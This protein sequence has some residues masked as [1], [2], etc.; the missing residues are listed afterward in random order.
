MCWLLFLV[1]LHPELFFFFLLCWVFQS[2]C[3]GLAAPTAWGILVPD[4]GLNP[5]PHALQ[6]RFLT[7]G[8]HRKSPIA[9]VLNDH[10]YVLCGNCQKLITQGVQ[11][12]P[13]HQLSGEESPAGHARWCLCSKCA[14]L[15]QFQATTVRFRSKELGRNG[16]IPSPGIASL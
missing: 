4:Q 12:K 10:F 3:T 13:D 8:P 14:C 11:V 7:T 2:Q 9:I 1:R 5:H 6:G 15:G 16:H